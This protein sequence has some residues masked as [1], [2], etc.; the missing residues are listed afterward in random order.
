MDVLCGGVGTLSPFELTAN[1]SCYDLDDRR[2]F[3]FAGLCAHG[4]GCVGGTQ[5][6]DAWPLVV[7]PCGPPHEG[8][9]L[10]RKER[11]LL[12]DFRHSELALHYAGHD[13][14][15]VG[16][17]GLWAR[18]RRVRGHLLFGSR[19]FYPPAI[20]LLAT[21]RFPLLECRAAEA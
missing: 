16:I 12:P 21:K 18:D 9:R 10:F 8:A 4:R 6:F 19:D 20:S 14:W 3:W 15:R 17:C 13:V 1:P 2:F 11:L 5:V 7:S